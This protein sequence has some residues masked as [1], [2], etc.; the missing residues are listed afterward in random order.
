M[1]APAYEAAGAPT[2]HPKLY[3]LCAASAEMWPD[4]AAEL[5]HNT[6]MHAGYTP[7]PTLAIATAEHERETLQNLITGL[8]AH[9]VDFARLSPAEARQYEPTL[10]A[11]LCGAL[12]LPN[13]TQVD[14]RK[15]LK[16]L[17]HACQTHKRID[18]HRGY[19]PLQFT[20][21]GIR[22]TGFDATLITAGW[23]SAVVKALENGQS[24]SLVNADPVLDEIDPYGGQMLSVEPIANGPT[25]TLR[26][27]DLYIVPKPDRIV[28][29]ATVEPGQV[30]DHVDEAAIQALHNRAASICPALSDAKIVET[31]AGVRPGTP[32]HAPL[33]GET[34]AK[35]LFVAAGHYRNGILLAPIT[36]KIMADL[37][38][39]QQTD[40]LAQAFAPSAY[41]YT[42]EV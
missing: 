9:N 33:L 24:L 17:L 20:E 40:N 13:D 23:Q 22:H 2:A 31:W 11:S 3:D 6:G 16:A 1:L 14:N 32:S 25:Y 4:W 15:T 36:A 8:Q 27:D 29:G 18:L 34:A 19:A 42:D 35:N 30:T 12:C 39:D 38:L 7:T 5:E 37:I 28:I 26:A 10:S 41:T 21:G